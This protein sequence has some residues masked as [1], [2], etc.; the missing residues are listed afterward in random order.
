MRKD[1]ILGIKEPKQPRTKL[2]Q[3]KSFLGI[4][5]I[6]VLE[7]KHKEIFKTAWVKN[8]MFHSTGKRYND[9]EILTRAQRVRR[10]W[11]IFKASK[12]I[13]VGTGCYV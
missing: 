4:I 5:V 9:G 13:T 8:S 11:K 3:R 7:I 6:K 1:F 2:S 12:E 10:Q